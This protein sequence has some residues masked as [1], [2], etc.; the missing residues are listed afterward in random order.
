[1]KKLINAPADVIEDYISGLVAATPHLARVDGLPIVVRSPQSAKSDD[2]VA[3]VSGGG[4]GHEP[5]HAGYVGEGMLDAAVLG[6]VFTSPS[7]DSVYAAIV[8]AATRR[9]RAA[10]RQELHGRQAE[11]RPRRRD[12]AGRGH[13][14]RDG[15]RRG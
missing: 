10:H 9:G 12:G 11:L 1:M 7:V 13:P 5:A 4:S 14:G 2:R 15:G 6:P 8:A 3:L